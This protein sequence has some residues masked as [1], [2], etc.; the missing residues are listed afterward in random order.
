MQSVQ[1]L[2]ERDIEGAR[3]KASARVVDV[4]FV[5]S[6]VVVDA[7]GDVEFVVSDVVVDA[8]GDVEFVV[9]VVE[10]VLLYRGRYVEL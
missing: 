10:D 6:D 1:R 5:V 3:V 2:L 8:V 9:D 7:V 4:E